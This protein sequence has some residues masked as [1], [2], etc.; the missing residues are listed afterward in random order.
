MVISH[1]GDD[2]IIKIVAIV[3]VVVA[4]L[5]VISGL[6]LLVRQEIRRHR[7]GMYVWYL[8]A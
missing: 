3:A 8:C 5:V 2:V 6:L 7:E 4:G 1:K